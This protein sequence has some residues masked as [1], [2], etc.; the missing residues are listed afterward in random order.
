[1]QKERDLRDVVLGQIENTVLESDK[2]LLCEEAARHSEAIKKNKAAVAAAKQEIV[3][4]MATIFSTMTNFFLGDGKT[5]WDK[6]FHEQTKKDPWTNLRGEEQSAWQD[7]FV[8]ML[9]TVFAN[10]AAE[11]QK[12]YL[13]LLWLSQPKTEGESLSPA[14]HDAGLLHCR[15][16]QSHP[17]SRCEGGNEG[18]GAVR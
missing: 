18:G 4:A 16:P 8:L 10:N 11:Q 5:P 1:L 15:A 2:E 6:I 7:C 12:F 17:F 14:F 9:K 13:T 3:A